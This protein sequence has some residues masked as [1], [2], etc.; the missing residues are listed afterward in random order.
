[1]AGERH[2]NGMLCVNPP[3]KARIGFVRP[4][5][6]S[7]SL[8]VRLSSW[9]SPAPTGRISMK[10]GIGELKYIVFRNFRFFFKSGTHI[11]GTLYEDL[12]T[13][14]CCRPRLYRHKNSLFEWKRSRV[15]V[16]A[17]VCSHVPSRL[18]LNGYP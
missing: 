7:V 13:C 11:L 12:N 16:R 5:C 14:Y 3:L 2:G 4:A 18:S 6:P 17:Y 9:N 1:M 8:S 15:L 10:F